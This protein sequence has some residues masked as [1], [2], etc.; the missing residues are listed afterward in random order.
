M[1]NFHDMTIGELN[2]ELAAC[3]KVVTHIPVKRAFRMNM[4]IANIKKELLARSSRALANSMDVG[5]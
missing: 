3:E 1:Q 2:H 4:R 5:G